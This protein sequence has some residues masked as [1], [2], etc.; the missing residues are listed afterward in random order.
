MRLEV[1]IRVGAFHVTRRVARG[2]MSEVWLGH[3]RLYRHHAAIKVL[4]PAFADDDELRA[5]LRT[6]VR[7]M[8]GLD[9]PGIATVLDTGVVD[10][11]A[12]EQTG[13][14]MVAGS[15]W[16]AMTWLPHGDL[17]RLGAPLPWGVAQPLLLDVLDALAHAHARG[18]VHRDLKPSNVLLRVEHGRVRAVLTDFGIAQVVA[19][20]PTTLSGRVIGTPQY[21]APE[22]IRGD[23]AAIGPP[24]D[25]YALGCLAYAMTAG[26]PPFRSDN[27]LAVTTMHLVDVPPPLPSGAARP[28]GFERWV[29][30]L[31]RKSPD[32]RFERAADAARALAALGRVD[33]AP[34]EDLVSMLG[35]AAR[36]TG[37]P[38]LVEPAE[39]TA[40]SPTLGIA[41]GETVDVEAVADVPVEPLTDDRSRPFGRRVPPA[42]EGL[43]W[44]TPEQGQGIVARVG[45]A[46]FGVR[47]LPLVGRV[48]VRDRLW[49]ALRATRSD[50]RPRV[51]IV[52]G[53]PGL[54]TRRLIDW[55]VQ[56]ADEL[57]LVDPLR[58]EHGPSATS[59]HG[60]ADALRRRFGAVGMRGEALDA[61]I[62]AALERCAPDI[63]AARRAS[64]AEALR[65]LVDRGGLADRP[66][67]RDAQLAAIERWMRWASRHRT[68]L[69]RLDDAQWSEPALQLATRLARAS[70]VA[71]LVVLTVRG[72]GLG[73]HEAAALEQLGG[74]DG[75][76]RFTIEPLRADEMAHLLI[77]LLG[78]SPPLARAIEARAGGRPLFALQVVAEW[79]DGESV[80]PGPDGLEAPVTPPIPSDLASLALRRLERVTERSGLDGPEAMRQLEGAAALGAAVDWVEWRAVTDAAPE[81]LGQL[82]AGLFDAG[83]ARP[84]PGGFAFTHGFVGEAL[85][86]RARA[87]GRWA[88]WCER[89]AAAITDPD[90]ADPRPVERR[91]HA[92]R[93]AA[94]FDRAS[95]DFTAAARRALARGRYRQTRRLLDEVGACLAA[96]GA[97][98]DDL[99][100]TRLIAMRAET[101]RHV[102]DRAAATRHIEALRRRPLPEDA[103]W[104]RAELARLD[105]QLAFHGG[106]ADA[107]IAAYRRAIAGFEQTADTAGLSRSLHGLGIALGLSGHLD[108][109]A[110]CIERAIEVA[111]AHEHRGD[112][113]WAL[114]ASAGVLL[115]SGRRGEGVA[116][117]VSRIF[118]R[119]E[120]TTGHAFSRM[121]LGEMFAARG[122]VADARAHLDAS[123]ELLRSADSAVLPEAL[124]ARARLAIQRE[125]VEDAALDLREVVELHLPRLNAF[126]RAEALLGYAWC[127]RH[128]GDLEAPATFA[129]GLAAAEHA[130]PRVWPT[131]VFLDRLAQR[132]STVEPGWAAEVQRLAARAW[133]P[134]DTR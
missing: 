74:L 62:A 2:G 27:P 6:E 80:V 57:G 101:A 5:Q 28:A 114:H 16:L 45:P 37:P 76:E 11:V 15:P 68:L 99:R 98:G 81:A 110:P 69:V 47:R 106:E 103:T 92:L 118:E 46:L 121:F 116:A 94:L 70:D 30:R 129:R 124:L 95:D 66:G 1:S 72:G 84:V 10:A 107:A 82:M 4:A 61:Q 83:L 91:G 32:E 25:L 117:R 93:A 88:T 54:G 104:A 52:E 112:H 102:G 31:L 43:E 86:A 64:T 108:A 23:D 9:H 38:T 134:L 50:R 13:G 111:H 123:V 97:A 85:A 133:A 53:G 119:L 29:E 128:G 113:A 126:Y 19:G 77:E 63:D 65:G 44:R 131:A 79:L 71:A 20:A 58:A 48:A 22:Q 36:P 130:L 42:P 127:R 122:E 24:T 109:A 21:M 75:V 55:L 120:M 59:D 87:A 39:R 34:M 105:G 7:A 89:S 3:H 33:D 67:R 56:R 51:C 14:A 132:L 41:F 78:L 49:A 90:P 73:A 60:L 18:V 17:S 100:R 40:R 96:A 8:A 115:W 125:A 26:A 12:A 35:R